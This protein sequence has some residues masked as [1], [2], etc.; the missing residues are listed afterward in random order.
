MIVNKWPLVIGLGV[1]THFGASYLVP[2]EQKD[3]GLFGGLLRWVW[4]WGVGDRGLLGTMNP[5]AMPIS[6]FF[7]AMAAAALCAMAA[8]ALLGIWVPL[9]WWRPLA[10]GGAVLLLVVM[11]GFFGSTK[12]LPILAAL[13]TIWIATLGWR[14][15]QLT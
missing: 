8:L 10:V 15:F 13:T 9:G 12:I 3:Q 14:A 7:I 1:L 6:G 11:A 2:L 5:S 4:P